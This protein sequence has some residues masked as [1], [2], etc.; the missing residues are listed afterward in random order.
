MQRISADRWG[1]RLLLFMA[2]LAGTILLFAAWIGTGILR[3]STN[4]DAGAVALNLVLV[5]FLA[6]IFLLVMHGAMYRWFLHTARKRA[7]GALRPDEREPE[8]GTE[9]TAPPPR[10]EWPWTLRL[11]HAFMYVVGI[12]TL[13]YV[14]ASY[15]DQLAIAR[16]IVRHSMGSASAGSLGSLL[17]VY[18]PMVLLSGL[19]MLLTCRQMRRRDAGLLDAR[20]KQLLEAETAWLFSFAGGF[21]MTGMLC[22]WTGNM[23]VQYL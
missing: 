9:P 1:R 22:N 21:T 13:L 6:T 20:E 15:A 23:I 12:A 2:W 18:L 3:G 5:V 19:A 14:F 17:F 11:R 16:F 8:F 4:R 7:S 10:I